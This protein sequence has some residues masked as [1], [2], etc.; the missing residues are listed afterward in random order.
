MLLGVI[1]LSRDQFCHSAAHREDLAA[2][3][4]TL[5]ISDKSRTYTAVGAPVFLLSPQERWMKGR[6]WEKRDVDVLVGGE[7]CPDRPRHSEAMTVTFV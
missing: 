4:R 2:W 3:S 6:G 5:S 1:I 7:E